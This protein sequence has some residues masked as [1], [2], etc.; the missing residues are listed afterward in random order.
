MWVTEKI[1]RARFV[2][3]EFARAGTD[4]GTQHSR[5]HSIGNKWHSFG[6][7]SQ[8]NHVLGDCTGGCAAW[9]A[10]YYQYSTGSWKSVCFE[11]SIFVC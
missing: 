7:S 5:A 6:A 10:G 8:I 3:P 4:P 9:A 1:K 11:F 2:A